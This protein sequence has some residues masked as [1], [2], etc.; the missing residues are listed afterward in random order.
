MAINSPSSQNDSAEQVPVEITEKL[1]KLEQYMPGQTQITYQ[2][3]CYLA[4]RADDELTPEGFD[5]LTVLTMYDLRTGINGFTGEPI[6]NSLVGYPPQ[7][8]TILER[9]IIPKIKGVI[10]REEQEQ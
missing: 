7:T 8:Y 4:T 6:K 5:V 10:F 9:I 2:L 3:A 1:R